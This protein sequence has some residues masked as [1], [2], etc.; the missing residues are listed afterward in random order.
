MG[1]FLWL[2]N[3][4]KRTHLTIYQIEHRV[5]LE[6]IFTTLVKTQLQNDFFANNIIIN[7]ITIFLKSLIMFNFTKIKTKLYIC[8]F[9]NLKSTLIGGY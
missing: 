9:N 1:I 6:K 3:L 4:I 2:L 5:K 8:I 7:M